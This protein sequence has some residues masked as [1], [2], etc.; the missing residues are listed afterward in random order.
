MLIEVLSV[1]CSERAL[2]IVAASRPAVRVEQF[3]ALEGSGCSNCSFEASAELRDD[4][5]SLNVPCA[6]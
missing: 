2:V 5:F 6:R 3:F 4:Q 1:D